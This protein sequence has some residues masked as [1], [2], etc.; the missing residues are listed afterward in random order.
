MTTPG[1]GIGRPADRPLQG[2]RNS[3]P[4]KLPGEA[5]LVLRPDEQQ[6]LTT[7]REV[8][9]HT[10]LVRG[11][12]EYLGARKLDVGGKDFAFK[13]AYYDTAEP[14]DR[15]AY[16]AINVYGIGR[17]EYE[18]SGLTPQVERD[19]VTKNRHFVS[20]SE[21][22]QT[23]GIQ[24]FATSPQER[25]FAAALV[26]EALYPV[27]WTAGFRLRLPYY[28]GAYASFEPASNEYLDSAEAAVKRDRQ[29]AFLVVARI[30][31]LQLKT[32]VKGDPRFKVEVSSDQDG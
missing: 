27:S 28:F 5:E 4:V 9:A 15:A 1:G 14:E 29:A 31:V 23:L 10:A 17:G 13:A 11:L 7:R 22:V 20:P 24:L 21:F 3:Y 32:F 12:A 19:P 25:G 6:V 2:P 26:E 16:P 18:A 30:K 8:D